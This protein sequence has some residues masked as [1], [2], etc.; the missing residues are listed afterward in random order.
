MEYPQGSILGPL[1]L[2]LYVNDMVYAV[3]CDL[4]LHADDT[5]LI[6]K[7]KD[8]NIIEQQLNR[9]FQKPATGS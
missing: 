7:H 6:F 9:N 2:L 4:L 5:D 8:I 1:L 3:N